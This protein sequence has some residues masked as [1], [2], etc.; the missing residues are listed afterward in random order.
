[1]NDWMNEWI[2]DDWNDN[3]KNIYNHIN[4]LD[5]DLRAP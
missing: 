4:I 2:M 1:M 3:K 5:L